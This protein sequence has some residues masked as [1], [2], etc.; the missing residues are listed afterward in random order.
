M[1]PPPHT[2]A[3]TTRKRRS[4]SERVRVTRA[5]DRCKRRKIKC[6]NSQ[7]CQFC[8]RA[9]TRCTF[10]SSY[11]RG[12]KFLIPSAHDDDGDTRSPSHPA[13]GYSAILPSP[14]TTQNNNDT[15][16]LQTSTTTTTTSSR[17]SPEPS[18]TDL[19]GH[20][21]GP[22][23]G[24]SFLLRVQKRLHQAISFSQPGSI[25]TFGDAPL[26]H[27]PD[28][29][30][31]FCMMLPRADAQKLIDRYFDFAMPTY[32]FL[33]RPT[34]QE[35]FGEFYDTLGVMRDKGSAP[36]KVALLFMVFSLARVYMPDDERPGP[37]DLSAR[38]YLAAEH[39]LTKEKGSIRLTS[40]QA[41]LTQCYYLLTQS[42]I[43]HCWSLF[44]TVSHLALA[45]GL[46]R[47][48]RPDPGSGI[49]PVE[50][51]C[52]RR[53][54]W[55]AYTLDAYLSAALGRPR[56]FHDEDVDTELPACV[57]DHELLTPPFTNQT[58]ARSINSHP[59]KS[60]TTMLAPIAHMKIARI[61]SRILR[62]LY[63]IRPLSETRRLSAAH[64]ITRALVAWRADLA[65]F[66]D[67][68]VLSASLIMPIFQRQR[69]VLNLTYWHSIILT[70]RPF[71]LS[72]F[73]R[74]TTRRGEGSSSSSTSRQTEESV[75]QCLHAAM[76]TVEIID[77]I[78]HNRQLFRAF[79]V[80]SYIAFNATIILY[81]YVIQNRAHLH[82][83]RNNDYFA[84]ATR[85]QSHLSAIAE[86]GS[87]SERYVLVLEELRVEATRQTSSSPASFQAG[88]IAHAQ[89]NDDGTIQ[90]RGEGQGHRDLSDSNGGAGVNDTGTFGLLPGHNNDASP[91]TMTTNY[92]ADSMG[93]QGVDLDVGV[94]AN[95]MG[96]I[97]LS[98]I[99]CPGWGQF[100]SM[101]S[102]GLGNMDFFWGDEALRF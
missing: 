15:N 18:Q 57:E 16:P 38:Y 58:P 28:F 81:I 60:L 73:G 9:K 55:C 76:K 49:S 4:N 5:C 96:G 54:F 39:Q 23:S 22:A 37:M 98:G 34:V 74:L 11:A 85:C 29:D 35:W 51:E 1:P 52:R 13:S 84:A 86:K 87:L 67:A 33:H 46:N 65:W 27:L 26:N 56:S 97:G 53:T 63:S 47:N 40:V 102:S 30:P 93:D 12:R 64:S 6:N 82:D 66:L 20:Y 89:L 100:T 92:T 68:D 44:G 72:D 17:L 88:G 7:P 41:R 48:R 75:K 21:I 19:Q 101:V 91:Q 90:R 83:S 78:T 10:D 14:A 50:A 31:S 45:I 95:G 59:N 62:D 99:D 70:H 2:P 80:T 42:R 77:Q 36:A 25:F 69:N 24:V 32:R 43:N 8:I 61:I 79:W 71:M 94:D 3:I